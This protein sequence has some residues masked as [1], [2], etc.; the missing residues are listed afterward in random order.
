LAVDL[1][2]YEKR[3]HIFNAAFGLIPLSQLIRDWSTHAGTLST[4]CP[5]INE[6]LI[7]VY[8]EDP[9]D[10]QNFYVFTDPERYLPDEH[11]QRRILNIVHQLHNDEKTVKILLFVGSRLVVPRKLQRYMEV[12]YDKGLDNDEIQAI[13]NTVCGKT[14]I[15]PPTD[16]ATIKSMKGLTSYEV[17]AAISQSIIKTK[18][19]A[20]NPKRI[21]SRYVA[22]FKRRQLHKTDLLNYVDVS[23]YSFD[24]VGGNA[25]FKAW[26]E[27]TKACW[28][29]E[30][31]KF[32]LKPPKGVLC[33][34]V[35]GCGKSLS[36][37][38]LGNAWRLPVIQFETG[39]LRSSLVGESESNV[40]RAINLVESVA[41]CLVWIDEAEK[42]LAGNQ[43]SGMSDAGTTSRMIG[44]LSTWLQ[45]TTAQVCLAMTANSLK[46][47]PVE[48]INRMNERWFYDLPS[49]E[50]RIE[51]LKI[52]L[53]KQKQ[54]T[55]DF[56]LAVLA[57]AARDMVG[58]E[59]EQA[60]DAAL[61]DSF[62]ADKEHLDH[63]ILLKELRTKPR[64]FKTMAD[65]LR[66]VLEWV[67]Y[68]KD[69]N[70]GIRARFASD[71]RSE[72]F[73]KFRE[74]KS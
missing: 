10:G 38:A 3:T 36:I 26:A 63:D 17:D 16:L 4:D 52:H 54:D 21:D 74:A 34:G 65:E 59:I 64:I 40:Y 33:V 18:K 5:G 23:A 62:D 44:I 20:V 73:M 6:S 46:T 32:G 67:G 41:P 9:R 27:K 1:A 58:R 71:Q 37:K 51:I 42:S 43:S 49:E 61:I 39:R 53:K 72:N 70:D 45:E 68:D 7:K 19:E 31:Q 57:E 11:V 50:E 12:I 56:Q 47:L 55:A 66:E 48:F 22:E 13:I 69:A 35:W 28:T 30:G 14:H 60:I 8:Q 15:K 25:R 24:Q 29:D 2:K